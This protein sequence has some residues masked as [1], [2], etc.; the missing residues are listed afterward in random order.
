VI[1]LDENVLESQRVQ[2]EWRHAGLRQIGE[3]VGRKGMQDEELVT[4]RRP[5]FFSRDSDFFH[6]KLCNDKSCLA[7]LDVGPLEVAHYARRMLRH[8]EFKTWSQRKGC[9]ARVSS[10]G[11]SVWRPRARRVV[12]YRWED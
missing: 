9:V 4:L 6:R 2:L 10:T 5:T 7:H 12:R 11:I 8:P 3:N 1:V